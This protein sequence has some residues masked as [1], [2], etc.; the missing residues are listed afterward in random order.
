MTQSLFTKGSNSTLQLSR[1]INLSYQST[2]TPIYDSTEI[3]TWYIS[4]FI[5]AEYIINVEYGVNERETIH[6]TV[7]A[8]PGNSS[9]TIYGRTSL[10]RELI[11]IR[12]DAT[13]SVAKLIVQPATSD[14]QGSFVSYFAN[15][16]R[17]SM[18]LYP[19]NFPAKATGCSWSSTTDS[20]LSIHVPSNFLTG[21]ILKGQRV[22]G[23]GIPLTATVLS[24]DKNTETLTIGNFSSTI[25]QATTD[26]SLNFATGVDQLNNSLHVIK[27]SKNFNSFAISNQSILQATTTDDQLTIIP[28]GGI[29]ITTNQQSKT[30]NISSNDNFF[31]SLKI[32]DNIL[33]ANSNQTLE[34][35]Q[36]VGISVIPDDINKRLTIQSSGNYD[37]ISVSNN[38]TLNNLSINGIID[39][40]VSASGPFL[41]A[42]TLTTNNLIVSGNLTVNGTTTTVNSTTIDIDDINITIGKGAT[43]SISVNGGGISLDGANANI[44]WNDSVQSWCSNKSLSPNVNNALD[45]GNN[46]LLW[47]NVYTNNIYGTLK[48]NSQPEITSLGTLSTLSVSG[49]S[50][51]TDTQTSTLTVDGLTSISTIVEKIVDVAGITSVVY[52][53][54]KGS[55]FYHMSPPSIDWIA[56]FVNVSIKEG[57]ATTVNIIV[58]QSVIAYKISSCSINGITQTILWQGSSIPTGS[59]SK[60]DI[61]AF[62][63][64]RRSNTWVVLASQT[65]NFG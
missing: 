32:E 7:V 16:A 52:E 62:T 45:L 38:T 12:T 40:N 27:P 21:V 35:I 18:P 13:N 20:T 30:L 29:N 31:S 33:H 8:M 59:S 14:L 63:F 15:Y 64:I 44:S 28:S 3:D 1:G 42:G 25:F 6:A 53:V 19:L 9:I 61:W 5:S 50:L 46:T 34:I 49:I 11:N 39:G 26:A 56:A 10:T 23:T 48:T 54:N 65:S 36:G 60:T 17:S 58:P 4:E 47:N 55:I 24:Y 41:I 43:T 22:I 37:S 57:T 51:L 2:S